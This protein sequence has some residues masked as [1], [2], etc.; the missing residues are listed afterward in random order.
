MKKNEII[1]QDDDTTCVGYLVHNENIQTPTPAV[2]VAHAWRGQDEFAREKAHELARMGYIAFAIDMFGNQK[3]AKDDEESSSLIKPFYLDRQLMQKRVIA[4]YNTLIKQPHVDTRRIGAIGFCF[5]GLTVIELL[6]SG[7]PVKSVVS[8]HG[9]LGHE[10]AKTVPIAP[11]IEG[12]L[13][14]L[15]GYEDPLVSFSDIQGVQKE[16]NDHKIDWQMNI[17]GLTSHA[18]TNPMANDR[19]KGLIYNEKTA[20]KAWSAM[21]NFFN[22][23]LL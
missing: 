6:R 9:I 12:S 10:G 13:L 3:N 18:F 7:T 5:G 19:V 4:A 22:E 11:G 8:F 1:Y 17:Y 21:K 2:L 14:I 23:T 15:H 20:K 16:L